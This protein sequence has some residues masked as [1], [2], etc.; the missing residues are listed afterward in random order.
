MDLG[1]ANNFII[2]DVETG[3][4]D[5]NKNPITQIAVKTINS[6]DFKTVAEYSTYVIPYDN[7]VCE[8][9]ALDYTNTNLADLMKGKHIG[10]VVK[11]IQAIF[12]Q[13]KECGAKMKKPVLVG[14]NVQFDIGFL[15]YAFAHVNEDLSKHISGGNCFRQ[16][17]GNMVKFFAPDSVCTMILARVLWAN[18]DNVNGFSLTKACRAANLEEFDAHEAMNDVNATRD[19]LVYF[20]NRMRGGSAGAGVEKEFKPRSVFEF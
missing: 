5:S 6:V 9:K 15:S 2:F 17:R 4:L 11:D 20:I 8:Q 7:L 14:H 13:I 12:K 19:L 16:L 10:E 1:K 3:G 18:D